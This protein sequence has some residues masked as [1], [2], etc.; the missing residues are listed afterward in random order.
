M[1]TAGGTTRL[2]LSPP[3]FFAATPR[4]LA[5]PAVRDWTQGSQK[6][7]AQDRPA[8]TSA[9]AS[10]PRCPPPPV[11]L[12]RPSPSPP[13]RLR[14]G[15][16]SRPA[17]ARPSCVGEARP[18]SLARNRA[19][20][21]CAHRSPRVLFLLCAHVASLRSSATRW[22]ARTRRTT[23]RT[24]CSATAASRSWACPLRPTAWT[25]SCVAQPPA[26]RFARARMHLAAHSCPPRRSPPPHAH[27]NARPG[28]VRLLPGR[29]GWF[30]CSRPPASP[31]LHRP[32]RL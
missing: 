11:P 30:L 17:R 18:C 20:L 22:C 19:L 10:T 21:R 28:G 12:S 29:E 31:P 4:A 1:S 14:P 24:P 15:R 27:A 3:A 6:R 13:R 26:H 5:A 25:S 7:R 32:T 8:S 23:W 9:P 16:L 2:P